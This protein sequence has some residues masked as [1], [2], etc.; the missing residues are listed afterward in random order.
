VQFLLNVVQPGTVRFEV[1]VPESPCD[2]VGPTTVATVNPVANAAGWNNSDVTV[3]LTATDNANGSGIKQI[4]Y[5]AS[6]GQ[7]IPLTT[8][9]SSSVSFPI[10]T[11]GPTIIT[12]FA[13]DNA[14]NTETPHTVVVNLDKSP[15]AITNLPAPVVEAPGPEGATVSWS[16]PTASDNFDP[17]P[18]IACSPLSGSSFPIGTTQV[19]C[20][21][22]DQ[23]G[24]SSTANFTVTVNPPSDSM[25]PVTSSLRTPNAN[26][27]G[28]NDSNVGISLSAAD[29]SGGSGVKEITYS[30]SGAQA[31]SS[32]TVN[33]ASANLLITAEGVTTITFFARDNAGNTEAAQTLV[34]RIDKSAPTVSCGSA[35]GAWHADNVSISC[36]ANDSV[37]GLSDSN[38]ANFNLATSVAANAETTNASTNS[39]TV[40]DLAGNCS[41]AGPVSGNKVDRKAS[42]ITVAAPSAGSY[43]LNQPVTVSFNCTDG[44]SGVGSCTG[45]T[46]NGGQLNTASVGAKT[47]TVNAN[48]NVGN[49]TAPSVVN[50]TV[51]FG[52]EVLFDQT[53]A[54][55]SG[56]TV[57]IKFR[58]VD[59]NGGN[60][61]SA[62]TVVHA[63]SVVQTGSQASPVVDD[64]GNA[65]PDLDFRYDAA[66]GG[67][68]FNLKTTG[69][70]TGSY[71][72]NFVAGN[73]ANIYSIGFQIRQ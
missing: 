32:V 24:N 4:S 12:F 15:P 18:S 42:I 41:N 44:G 29:N 23:A 47:F 64:A 28:W 37:S 57:P 69:Y 66:L 22:S 20:S 39:R 50:Y 31:I 26:S 16:N 2:T 19:V 45:T 54:H 14:S 21:S 25:A 35:D 58:L 49:S 63:V 67:Y 34:V 55:K 36:T 27:H 53:K 10:N 61:S 56:S 59:A 46:A 71:V 11:E 65:N 30:A 33:G 62:A 6:G 3:L 43:I 73:G 48:D 70:G 8:V 7:S 13:R 40:C 68:I 17:S 9:N 38:D 72:L 60:V 51:N 5:V 1:D 52:I